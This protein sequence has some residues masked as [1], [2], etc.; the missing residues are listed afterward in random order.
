MARKKPLRAIS[1]LW[2]VTIQYGGDYSGGLKLKHYRNNSNFI[3]VFVIEGLYYL[4]EPFEDASNSC[5]VWKPPV[6]GIFRVS[7]GES[8]CAL[9][10]GGGER[11][12]AFSTFC[13]FR[14]K[15]SDLIVS[16]GFIWTSVNPSIMTNAMDRFPNLDKAT[17]NRDRRSYRILSSR[18]RCSP[19]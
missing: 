18:I 9:S 19:Q 11:L 4:L 12:H 6:T 1:R 15:I 13:D 3:V 2:H 7:N 5:D 17:R 16:L 10:T 14:G 8:T